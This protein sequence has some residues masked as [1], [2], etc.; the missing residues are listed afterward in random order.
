MEQLQ[1]QVNHLTQMMMSRGQHGTPEDHIN[2][3]AGLVY[4]YSMLSY[5][6]QRLNNTWIIDTGASNHMCCDRQLMT[7]I[8]TSTKPFHVALPNGKTVSVNQ[9]DTSTLSLDIT[10]VNVL[11]ILEFN[12]NLYL[13]AN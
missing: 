4:T 10:L 5:V 12:D 8:F 6:P 2:R 1:H 3:V 9:V 11:L 13:L 7:N